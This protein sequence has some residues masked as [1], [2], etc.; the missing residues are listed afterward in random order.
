MHLLGLEIVI[1]F[2]LQML[3]VALEA[4]NLDLGIQ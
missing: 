3:I 2:A 1:Y 4:V